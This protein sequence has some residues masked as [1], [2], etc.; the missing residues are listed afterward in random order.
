M[1]RTGRLAEAPPFAA[2]YDPY[3]TLKAAVRIFFEMPDIVRRDAAFHVLVGSEMK[4]IDD[5]DESA[6]DS[7]FS[8]EEVADTRGAV[9]RIIKA[10]GRS[11][12]REACRIS[13]E[14]DEPTE[15]LRDITEELLMEL[16]KL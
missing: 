16:K 15:S 2:L 6:E 14:R 7:Y 9:S 3:L 12:F 1:A 8:A 13:E 5:K 11:S 10:Y 4:K